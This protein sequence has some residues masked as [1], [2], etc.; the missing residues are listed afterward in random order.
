MDQGRIQYG[1]RNSITKLSMRKV[2][3]FYF[4]F[5]P[6]S[7]LAQESILRRQIDSIVS[8]I[9]AKVIDIKS[10]SKVES[11][12]VK[13]RR[14]VEYQFGYVDGEVQYIVRKFVDR[15]S[16]VKQEFYTKSSAL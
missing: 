16:S 10:F 7:I 11:V 6:T 5:F 14:V 3:L 15:D 4:L 9:D 13:Q 8:S 1:G 12:A 2:H